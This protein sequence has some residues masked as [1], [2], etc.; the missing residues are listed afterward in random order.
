MMTFSLRPRLHLLVD[1][2]LP[3]I[4]ALFA[5]GCFNS[6]DMNDLKCTTSAHCP[7]GY[8][9]VAQT[10]KTE[11]LC[12]KSVDSGSTDVVAV[13]DGAAGV[14]GQRG[15]DANSSSD[16]SSQPVD[17][18][19]PSLDSPAVIDVGPPMD[20]SQPQDVGMDKPASPDFGPD[21]LEDTGIVA[22]PDS[23]PDRGQDT[24][25]D[26][27]TSAPDL[28]PDL[29]PDLPPPVPDLGLDLPTTQPLGA[30]CTQASDCSS[31]FCVS[32][33]CCNRSCSGASK[34]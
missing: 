3:A 4:V 30:T 21:T 34:S 20:S 10:G 12:A 7:V 18:P 8:V 11:G 14:D 26:A 24:G 9:C 13:V 1:V 15:V 6:P 2:V 28:P 16:G 17:G 31:N 23:A 25:S 19:A 5:S 27:P 33:V 29:A 32:G 22:T